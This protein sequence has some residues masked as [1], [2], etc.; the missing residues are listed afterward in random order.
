MFAGFFSAQILRC[1]RFSIRPAVG[2]RHVVG[3]EACEDSWKTKQKYGS[4]YLVQLRFYGRFGSAVLL[5]YFVDNFRFIASSSHP[6]QPNV[7]KLGKP[8]PRSGL[9]ENIRD[10]MGR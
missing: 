1:T 6:A 8:R 5:A 9:V 4:A 7:C 10:Q 3:D 2:D